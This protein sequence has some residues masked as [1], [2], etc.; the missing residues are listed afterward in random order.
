MTSANL[1]A[2]TTPKHLARLLYECAVTAGL[3]APG[4]WNAE[5]ERAYLLLVA[6]LYLAGLW[7]PAGTA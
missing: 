5:T 7:E 4:E 2:K 3:D 6:A 1:I